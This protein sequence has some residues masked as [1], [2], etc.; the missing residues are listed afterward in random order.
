MIRPQHSPPCRTRR[1]RRG[2]SAYLFLVGVATLM[3]VIGLALAVTS[4]LQTRSQNLIR[5][6][7]DAGTYAAS[8]V[9]HGL[10]SVAATSTWR[11]VY[12]SGS[13]I[14][15][16]SFGRGS[17]QWRLVDEAD[18]NLSNNPAQPAR[19]YGKATVGS[20]CRM[21]SVLL[22]VGADGLAHVNPASYRWEINP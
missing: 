4:R 12:T 20:A 5:D 18:G 8:A 11:T 14:P 7:E 2:G 3:T 13:W 6:W 9:E 10:A 19:L 17:F 22:E 1:S 16:K 15:A 21:Y